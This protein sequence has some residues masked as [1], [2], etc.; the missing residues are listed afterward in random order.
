MGLLV[1]II[2]VVYLKLYNIYYIREIIF[3]F[4][5]SF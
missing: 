5:S 2:S 1:M 4:V 3:Y